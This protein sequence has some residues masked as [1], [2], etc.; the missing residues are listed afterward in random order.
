MI[1]AVNYFCMDNCIVY[2]EERLSTQKFRLV[3]KLF[4]NSKENYRLAPGASALFTG[5][6]AC[7]VT[8]TDA[9]IDGGAD[10]LQTQTLRCP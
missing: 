10:V 3:A 2:K 8:G 6:D 7:I 9:E 4:R 5:T 1:S